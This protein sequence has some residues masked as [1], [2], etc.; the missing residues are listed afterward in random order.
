MAKGHKNLSD[1]YSV[2]SRYSERFNKPHSYGFSKS[3]KPRGAGKVRLAGI[4]AD[5]AVLIM[6]FILLVIWY[7]LMHLKP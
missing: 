2:C 5:V 7:T 6:A 1:I 3:D 4:S